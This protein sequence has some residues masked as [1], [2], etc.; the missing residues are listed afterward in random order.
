MTLLQSP[1]YPSHC[2]YGVV[3]KELSAQAEAQMMFLRSI[4]LTP[5]LWASW[6]ELAK[7]CKDRSMV[8]SKDNH[9]ANHLMCTTDVY[10]M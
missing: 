9:F 7:I 10:P 2:S 4:F 3:L 1:L 5:L 8:S 6:H